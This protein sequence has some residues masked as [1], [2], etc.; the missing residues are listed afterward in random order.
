M[1]VDTLGGWAGDT[2][3]EGARAWPALADLFVATSMIFLL[4]FVVMLAKSLSGDGA[5]TQELFGQLKTLSERRQTFTVVRD[6][7]DVRIV[8]EESVSFPTRASAMDSIKPAGRAALAQIGA[9][10]KQP[11]YAALIREIEVVGHADERPVI[12]QYGLTNWGLS[13]ARATSVAEYLVKNVGLDPCMIIPSG[14][15]EYFPRDT[16]SRRRLLPPEREA[17]Y[18]RDRRIEVLLHPSMRRNLAA[19][20]KSCLKP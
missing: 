11:E 18:A 7:P 9:L 6:G 12:S 1:D 20:A 2:G 17:A 13:T 14:R 4:L 16:V 8:L 3:E 15:G 10:L 19:E 5:K